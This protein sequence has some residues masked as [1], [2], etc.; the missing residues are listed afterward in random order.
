MTEHPPS[1]RRLIRLTFGLLLCCTVAACAVPQP[2]AGLSPVPTGVSLE[3]TLP[4][5]T[6]DPPHAPGIADLLAQR[7]ADGQTVEVD[8][9]FS[10]AGASTWPGSGRQPPQDDRVW[11][12]PTWPYTL[13]DRPYPVALSYLNTTTSNNLSGDVPWLIAAILEQTQ[14]NMNAV[15]A[16]PYHARLAGHFGDPAF[17][18][19]EC[20]HADRIFVVEHVVRVYQESAPDAQHDPAVP[21]DYPAWPR[22]ADPAQ[23]YSVPYPPDWATQIQDDGALALVGPQWP[24]HPVLMRVHTGELNYDQYDPANAPPLLRDV[25]GWGQ[26]QQGGWPY[27][28]VTP[29][30]QGLTGFVVQR[31]SA[32]E[33]ERPVAVLFGGRGRTYEISVSYPTGFAAA[34]ELMRDYT[35]I[36]QGFRLDEAPGPTATPPIRQELGPGPFLTEEQ[37]FQKARERAESPLENLGGE[38]LSEAAARQ[39]VVN[40]PCNTFTGHPEGVWV[41]RVS[42]QFGGRAMQWRLLLGAVTGEQLCGEEILEGP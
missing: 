40:S 17:A 39:L 18:G 14:P 28:Q 6:P 1:W 9:Y 22:Y 42:G 5:F 34:P 30:T 3:P 21:A 4:P 29:P 25:D 19:L 27:D 12:P 16:L 8:A 2:G 15:P 33:A 31:K 38:L 41:L 32:S 24:G 7:P 36:V 13:T 20:Q 10:A 26:F 35:G 11:C 23:G 37:A